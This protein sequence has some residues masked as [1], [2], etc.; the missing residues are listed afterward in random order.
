VLVY[1]PRG[2]CG[3]V[4]EI[5]VYDRIAGRW[6]PHPEHPWLPP[7]ACARE[8]AGTLLNELRVRCADPENSRRPSEWVVGAEVAST[9]PACENAP[10]AR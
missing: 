1:Y 8:E 9:S 10:R 2:D 6:A 4:L 5:E 3:G 7:G